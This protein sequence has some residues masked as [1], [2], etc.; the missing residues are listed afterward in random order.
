MGSATRTKHDYR[1]HLSP[2]LWMQA[3]VV[4]KKE[5]RVNYRCQICPFDRALRRAAGANI[6]LRLEGQQPGGKRHRIVFWKDRLK[7]LPPRKRPC[8]HSMKGRITFRTCTHDYNCADCEFDQFFDDQHRVHAIVTPVDTLELQGFKIPQGYYFHR[9][10]SWVKVEE[11]STVRV[12]MDDFSL[13]LLGPLDSVKAPLLGKEVQQDR[14]DITVCRDRQRAKILSPVCGVV[15]AINPA[16]RERG[17]LANERPF[18]KGWIMMVHCGNLRQDLKNL[19]INTETAAFMEEEVSDLYEMIEES[20]GPLAAD[21][22]FLGSDIH[23]CVPEIGWERLT[24]RF[25]RT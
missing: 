10:H 13:R 21:G 17:S 11:G 3:G 4:K 15:S 24:R 9:G 8:V 20:A 5:C 12:G 18:S 16:L 14:A 22:G 25:L 2:C 1:N 7:T 6:S 23:G 19:M